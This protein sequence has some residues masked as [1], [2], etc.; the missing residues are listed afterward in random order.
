MAATAIVSVRRK[1]KLFPILSSLAQSLR[2]LP[3]NG[4]PT[5]THQNLMHAPHSFAAFLMRRFYYLSLAPLRSSLLNTHAAPRKSTLTRAQS[6][7]HSN[8]RCWKFHTLSPCAHTNNEPTASVRGNGPL[9]I[10]QALHHL[11][12][13]RFA[14]GKGSVTFI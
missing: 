5:S 4:N 7:S 3:R 12:L 13:V 1:R 6:N 9:T 11:F 14:F 8:Q 10:S 2:F